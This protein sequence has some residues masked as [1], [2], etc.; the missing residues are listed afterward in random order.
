MIK[1]L[2]NLRLARQFFGSEEEKSSHKTTIPFAASVSHDLV[3]QKK[4]K[5]EKE[6]KAGYT[7]QDAPSMRTSHLRK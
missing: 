5:E 6:N 4:E 3:F 1:A 2:M 7:A